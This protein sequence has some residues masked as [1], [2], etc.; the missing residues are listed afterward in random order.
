MEVS[1]ED[2]LWIDGFCQIWSDGVLGQVDGLSLCCL[3]PSVLRNGVSLSLFPICRPTNF[4]SFISFVLFPFLP[5]DSQEKEYKKSAAIF[6]IIHVNHITVELF[7]FVVFMCEVDFKEMFNCN[8]I[9]F[10]SFFTQSVVVC[11]KL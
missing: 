6:F 9:T 2:S 4:S 5:F 7:F 10:V 8:V 3:Y 11:C 1:T